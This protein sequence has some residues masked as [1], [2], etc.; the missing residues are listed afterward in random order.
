MKA[1]NELVKYFKDINEEKIVAIL[2]S[3]II[4]TSF[5]LLS[6]LISYIIIKIFKFKEKDKNKI[7]GN[8]FYL[9]LKASVIFAGL[10]IAVVELNLPQ[11][12]VNIWN[13]ILKVAVICIV[14]K[15]LINL[16]D[17]KSE[18]SKKFRK[19]NASKKDKTFANFAGR[20]LKYVIYVIAALLIIAS[21]GYNPSGLMAGLGIGGAI[22]ALA[23]QDIVKSLISGISI[24]TDKPFLV[25]DL[26]EVGTHLG[27]VLD[28]TFRATK[29][30]T[31]DNT[32]VTLPNSTITSTP[33]INWSRLQ[34]RRYEL[35]LK[36][37]LGTD[38]ERV[39]TVVN[40]IKF[41][42][43]TNGDILPDTIQVHFNTLDQNGINILIY[44]YTEI[45]N[46]DEYMAF[47]QRVNEQ[48]LKVL[49]SEEV[50]LSYPGQNVYLL[51]KEMTE[52]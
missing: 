34:Q 51:S 38:S 1:I 3:I 8:P 12:V 26:I 28:I 18:I 49:E 50:R 31:L 11:S 22:V 21:L 17:P 41:V 29:I 24:L 52:K 7:K 14:S 37:P 20:I 36:L 9:P 42:L 25:G 30:N 44:L 46:Y 16:V 15:G 32:I 10:A 19:K 48:I 5:C 43:Q 47:R 33:I 39:E 4:V 13:K 35:N 45:I 27:V 40:K 23:A 6:S 2:I